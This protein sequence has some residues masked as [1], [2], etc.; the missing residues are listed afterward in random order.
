[1]QSE[2]LSTSDVG[3]E[4]RRLQ[5]R[6]AALQQANTQVASMFTGQQDPT[7]VE[8]AAL[9]RELT[10]RERQSLEAQLES[11]RTQTRD[12]QVNVSFTRPPR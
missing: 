6:L 1:M 5:R 10:D 7:Q 3:H 8:A 9:L 11:Y 2:N 4:V 12:A